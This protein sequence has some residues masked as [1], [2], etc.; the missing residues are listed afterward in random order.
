[1]V[2]CNQG[3]SLIFA[4]PVS[5]VIILDMEKADLLIRCAAAIV[6]CDE[7]DRIHRNADIAIKDGRILCIGE[8]KGEA[9][10]IIDGRSLFVYPGLVNTHHHYYQYF[11]RN[12][13]EVQNLELFPWLTALY[14]IWAGLAPETVKLSAECAMAELIRHGCTTSF[15]HHY[16]FPGSSSMDMLSAEVEAAEEVGMRSCLSR[17]SMDLSRKD[18]G[19]PPDSVVQTIDTILR[20]SEEAVR[21]F[22]DPSPGSMMQIALAPCSPFSVTEDLL[23][24]SAILA[25]RLGV[26]LHT[27][28]AETRDENGYVLTSKGMRPLEYME[29]LGWTG[30]DVWYAHGIHFT[31]EEL[32]VLAATGTGIAHC[33]ASN[34]K[35]GSGICKVP[36]M[37]KRGIPVSLGVDGSASNDG[38][39]LMA[40][41]R[42]CYLL[43][44]LNS[45]YDAPS[46]YDVLKM[47]TV[48]GAKVL[49]RSDI[50]CLKE[51]MCADLFAIDSDCVE[52][53]GASFSPETM[54]S[55]IG[56]TRPVDLT[57]INGRIAAEKG[58][59]AMIDESELFRKADKEIH[60][61]LER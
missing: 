39:D 3:K 59:L 40:E 49:G 24:E 15:D 57:V 16:V 43:H 2:S 22:H 29:K 5:G 50:G 1:M 23:R 12:L 21:R 34:M 28:L 56:L 35:L 11:S 52:L 18:G 6:S 26:R 38:S 14:D 25:R 20:D 48:G 51:G 7:S 13:P 61:Y 37:L 31:D 17:G 32:D 19:L 44:R 4:Y 47:A 8:F 58:H 9:S 45:S 10:R 36:E 46:G 55:A 33:P 54:L 41:M 30:P 27:H 60:R 53:A 42:T